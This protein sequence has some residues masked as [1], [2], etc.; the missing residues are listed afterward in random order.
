MSNDER[1]PRRAL[2]AIAMGS[3]LGDRLQNLRLGSRVASGLL[4]DVRIS[5]VY[6]TDPVDVENQPLF[7]NACCVGY[8]RLP[9]IQILS[10]LQKA[11]HAAGR[12]RRRP[13]YGPR[14]LDLDLLVYGDL[15]CSDERLT[16][17]HPRLRERAFVLLP[18]ADVAPDLIVPSSAGEPPATVHELTATVDQAG[19]RLTKWRIDRCTTAEEVCE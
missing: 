10:E 12:R 5:P 18:L 16:L 15:T 3:N 6:E 14:L 11:E 7:L 4:T 2:V 8:T 17:P 19:V 9:P 13:R 1:V